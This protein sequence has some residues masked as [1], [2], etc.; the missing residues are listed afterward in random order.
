MP[1][2]SEF[3]PL[4][5]QYFGRRRQFGLPRISFSNIT[6]GD[7]LIPPGEWDSIPVA[8][9]ETVAAEVTCQNLRGMSPV[10]EFDLGVR[11]FDPVRMRPVSLT[12]LCTSG[13]VSYR[14]ATPVE[15]GTYTVRASAR[16]EGES[17]WSYPTTPD[18]PVRFSVRNEPGISDCGFEPNCGESNAHFGSQDKRIKAAGSEVVF[19]RGDIIEVYNVHGRRLFRFKYGQPRDRRPLASI[20]PGV[21]LLHMRKQN[22]GSQTVR[23]RL[24]R[25]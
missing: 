18:K 5:S 6:V 8:E 21:Y 19:R 4:G 2:S 3:L 13:T 7:R 23:M 22:E 16:R 11:S 9:C 10:I 15:N 12:R 1:G 17:M 20:V 24:P 25:L 14:Y